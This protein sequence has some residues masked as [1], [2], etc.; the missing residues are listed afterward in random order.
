MQARA[1]KTVQLEAPDREGHGNPD[2]QGDPE[3]DHEAIHQAESVQL[4][5]P[6]RDQQD[7][8]DGIGKDQRHR[9]H[10]QDGQK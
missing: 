6:G 5:A 3:F 8:Q 9:S 1:N 2:I 7:F 4:H 10:N